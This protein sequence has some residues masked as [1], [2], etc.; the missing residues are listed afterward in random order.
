MQTIGIS[1]IRAGDEFVSV[2]TKTCAATG[3]TIEKIGRVNVIFGG[4][5][6]GH[7]T[8]GIKLPRVNLIGGT[9]RRDGVLYS[10]GKE[11]L[12]T[13]PVCKPYEPNWTQYEVIG[14]AAS[15]AEAMDRY[16]K[17]DRLNRPGGTR[18]RLIEDRQADINTAGHTCIASFH[19]SVN[20]QGIYLRA[21]AQAFTVYSSKLA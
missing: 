6:M 17:S 15:V 11:S 13:S 21:D 20:G 2:E 1:E 10:I 5:Y 7:K 8:T 9:L 19:D 16:Y 12:T 14:C 3:G 4:D 18:D